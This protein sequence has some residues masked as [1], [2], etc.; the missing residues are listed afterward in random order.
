MKVVIFAGGLGTR[1]SEETTLVPK[2]MIPIN[3]KPILWH[4]MKSYS[5]YGFNDFIILTGYKSY[6]IKDYFVNYHLHQSN[7]S[8]D[9]MNNSVEFLDSSTEP[10]KVTLLDTGETTLTGARLK[11]ASQ[12]L[13][14]S[15]F[16]LTYGDGVSDI[17]MHHQLAFHDTH[18]G[19]VTMAAVQPAGRFGTFT[20]A[21]DPSKVISFSEKIKTD[22]SWIN[23]GFFICEPEI[24]DYIDNQANVAF[25]DQPLSTLADLGLLYTYYH[26]GFWKCMDTL[27]DKHELH[28]IAATSP[29]WLSSI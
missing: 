21:D 12:Y 19:I 20:T 14:G 22:S 2:P 29:Y 10:W 24:L 9:I 13:T 8:V 16:L 3:G 7:I 15:R 25:E 26:H 28:S 1:L 11:L 27:R 17:D 6:I 4:I 5:R 23:G 18:P